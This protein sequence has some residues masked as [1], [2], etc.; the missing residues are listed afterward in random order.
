MIDVPFIPCVIAFESSRV[1]LIEYKLSKEAPCGEKK[2]GAG[3]IKHISE[4]KYCVIILTDRTDAEMFTASMYRFFTT[5]TF[6]FSVFHVFVC[7][8][9]ALLSCLSVPVFFV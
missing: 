2:N 9:G 5:I 3:L 1:L 4:G 6:F 8:I 7:A